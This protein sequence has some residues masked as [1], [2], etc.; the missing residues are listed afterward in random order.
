MSGAPAD[1]G[2]APAPTSETAPEALSPEDRARLLARPDLILGDRDLMRALIGAR[3]AD[4]GDNVIDIRGRAMQALES[5]LDRLE[6]A[7]ESVI[8][9][10]YE[11]QSGMNT[12]HRAVISLLE[13]VDF[14]GFLENLGSSVAPILRIDT[15]RLLMESGAAPAADLSGP[16]V[17][18][19]A[20]RIAELIRA[21][22]RTP[23]GDDIVLRAAAA[24]T[25]PYHEG[26]RAPIRSEALLPIDLGPQR[27]PA[28]LL[29]GSAEAGRFTPAQGTDLLRFFGQVFRLVLISW[30][31]E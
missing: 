18:T 30:L 12:I 26:A 8:S 21:G 4:L 16:L 22:R 24:E 17:I 27:F 7:H 31:R 15:L 13:P 9:A 20:G 2:A 29:M 3:D 5:R 28:L 10:A 23:R 14:D 25:L 6:S 1:P 19:P 11:N